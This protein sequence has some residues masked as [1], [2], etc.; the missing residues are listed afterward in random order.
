LLDRP[1]T[2]RAQETGTHHDTV[3]TLHRRFRQQGML[4]LLPGNIE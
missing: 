1:A 4:G 2:Q 3:R